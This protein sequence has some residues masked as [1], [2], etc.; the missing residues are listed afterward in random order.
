[1]CALPGTVGN[2][3]GRCRSGVRKKRKEKKM[4]GKRKIRT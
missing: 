4:G 2:K 1:M 3:H